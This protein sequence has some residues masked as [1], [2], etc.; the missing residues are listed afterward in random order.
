M[1]TPEGV[2][3]VRFYLGSHQPAWLSRMPGIPLMVSH[4]RLAGMRTLPVAVTDWALDSGGFTELT[5]HGRWHT[6]PH[7]Y[8]RA[9]RRYADQIGRLAW[10][11]YAGTDLVRATMITHGD[12]EVAS[13]VH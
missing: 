3:G 11:A 12:D 5:L 6:S 13:R 8:L 4:R 2:A 1:N 7:H 9:V 10:A